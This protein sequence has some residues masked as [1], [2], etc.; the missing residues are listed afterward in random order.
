MNEVESGNAAA[1][2][3]VGVLG[4]SHNLKEHTQ[5]R[6]AF[7]KQPCGKNRRGKARRRFADGAGSGVFRTDGGSVGALCGGFFRR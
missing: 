3:H 5:G 2:E 1:K 6:R 4:A 7:G